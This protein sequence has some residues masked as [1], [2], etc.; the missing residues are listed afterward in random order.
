MKQGYVIGIDSGTTQ[1]KAVL[2]DLKGNEIYVS[3]SPTPVEEPEYGWA[4]NN[5]DTEW[6]VIK[7]VFRKLFEK[8]GVKN[9]EILGVGIV[10]K[11]VGLVC[12]DE[13]GRPLRNGI[14]WNDA[15]C[16]NEV[17]EKA[18]S[19][20]LAEIAKRTGN[21][22]FASDI[23]FLVPWMKKNEP[24]ILNKTRWFCVNSNMICHH[25]TGNFGATAA[26]FF[27]EIG[28]TRQYNEEVLKILGLWEYREKFLPLHDSWEIAGYVTKQAAEETGLAEGTPVT[29]TNFDVNGCTVGVGAV[30]VGQAN[31]ILGTSGAIMVPKPEFIPGAKGSQDVSAVPDLWNHCIAPYAGTPNNDWFINN[32]TYADKVRAEKEGRSIFS[33]F[34]EELAKVNPGCNGVIYHPYMNPGGERQPFS[35][36][37]ARANFF[38][39]TV[40]TDRYTMLRAVYEGVA[41]SNKHCLDAYSCE[42]D[43]V[44]LSG[45]GTQSPV[46]CQIF[47][48][49]CDKSISLPRGTEFGAKGAAL[50]AAYAAGAF[51]SLKEATNAF[52]QVERVY[53]PIPENVKIYADLYEVYKQIPAALAPAW[54]ARANFLLKHG[55][56]G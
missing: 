39:L 23:G 6:D 10:G 28:G 34:D 9:T 52:C 1:I 30:A 24:E 33:L 36:K 8:S 40:H 2:F 45:A 11:S 15:R 16:A 5:L 27:G 37:N 19:G 41:F 18:K 22:L 49:I 38:G 54:E 31:V 7:K 46:W 25:L 44:R 17:V 56:N 21:T 48:D 29:G 20:T 32:F 4:E 50:I 42:I 43:D 53:E 12:V 35:D 26:D 47:A 3:S 14:L 51:G 13:N 55:F